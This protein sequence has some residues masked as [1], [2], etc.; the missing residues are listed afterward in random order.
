ML[1]GDI[2]Q[3]LKNRS[4]AHPLVT[5]SDFLPENMVQIVEVIC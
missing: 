2:V 5:S 4:L 1:F 3:S